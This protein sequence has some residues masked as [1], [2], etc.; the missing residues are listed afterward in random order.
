MSKIET[1]KRLLWQILKI[2][3]IRDKE[4]KPLLQRQRLPVSSSDKLLDEDRLL[5]FTGRIKQDRLREWLEL[6]KILY[7]SGLFA[8]TFMDFYIPRAWK[9]R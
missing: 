3:N 9:I 6:T 8:V 7:N 4:S 1:I 2:K 5:V